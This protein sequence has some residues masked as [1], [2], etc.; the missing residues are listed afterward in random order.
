MA[1]DVN[2]ADIQRGNLASDD[3]EGRR[4]WL[5]TDGKAGS[6][7]QAEGIATALGLEALVKHANPTG[8]YRILAPFGPVDPAARFGAEDGDF[9]P[10]W[11]DI[12]IAVGRRSAPYLRALHKVAPGR[13]F[14][15]YLMDP[16]AGRNVADMIWVPAHDRLRGANVFTTPTAPHPFTPERLAALRGTMADDIAALPQ[17]RIAI[18]IGGRSAAY[19]FS[20]QE[21]TAFASALQSLVALGASFMITPSRR[22]HAELLEATLAATHG[23]PRLVIDATTGPN[24]YPEFLAHAEA[25]VVTADSIN[26]TGEAAA[27]GRPVYVFHPS[28]GRSKFRRFHENLQAHGV[29]RPLPETLSQFISWHYEP[30]DSTGDIAREISRRWSAWR[31]TIVA[32]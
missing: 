27:T 11:P 28:G 32:V 22:T 5:I 24:R 9:G 18:L 17:P 19:S 1:T 2:Q 4:A 10:P 13:C 31:E 8:L 12:A 23:T 25:F 26:M 3:L 6:T 20:G 16:R 29:T 21:T 15:V 14:S 7:R 30:I